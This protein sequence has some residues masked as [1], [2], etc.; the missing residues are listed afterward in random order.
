MHGNFQ[1][2]IRAFLAYQQAHPDGH[3]RSRSQA[4]RARQARQTR[5][6]KCAPKPS[7]SPENPRS[8]AT[9]PGCSVQAKPRCALPV[10]L[11]LLPTKSRQHVQTS[12]DHT[13]TEFASNVGCRRKP[14]NVAPC[15]RKDRGVTPR[16]ISSMRQDVFPHLVGTD[17]GRIDIARCISRNTRCRRAR[18]DSVEVARIRNECE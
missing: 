7:I 6:P 5:A 12:I 13:W 1:Y 3:V 2:Q 8:T 14:Q 10:E 18:T 9:G 15:P 11:C 17:I 4:G 16:V